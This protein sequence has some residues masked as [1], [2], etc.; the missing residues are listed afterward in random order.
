L[1]GK[2]INT[3]KTYEDYVKSAYDNVLNGCINMADININATIFDGTMFTYVG[4][5]I[6]GVFADTGEN[7]KG[8]IIIYDDVTEQEIYNLFES[9]SDSHIYVNIKDMKNNGIVTLRYGGILGFGYAVSQA[10]EI[11]GTPST[12]FGYGR[13]L[14]LAER[15]STDPYYSGHYSYDDEGIPTEIPNMQDSEYLTISISLDNQNNA[16][17]EQNN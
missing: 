12:Y 10:T 14:E 16:F 2:I 1:A 15:A 9:Y 6:G 17:I 4:G 13:M 3:Y 7:Y 5:L 8:E 11:T